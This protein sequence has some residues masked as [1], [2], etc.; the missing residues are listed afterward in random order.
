MKLFNQIKATS[1]ARKFVMG[2]SRKLKVALAEGELRAALDEHAIVAFTDP[3]GKITSVNDKFCTISKYSREELIGQDHRIINS[4]FHSKEF[5]RDLWTTI[6][7]GKVWHGEIKNRAKDGSFYWVDTTIVPFL[8][9]VG[10]PRQYVAIRADITERKR[11]EESRVWLAAIVNSSDDAIIA[12]TLEGII[13]SW[14]SG[15]AKIFGYSAA[16]AIG[17]PM[18]M[19]FPPDRVNEESEIL[20]RI[21]RGESVKHYETIRVRKGGQQVDVSVTIS[22]VTDGNGKIIGA[23]KIARDITERKQMEMAMRDSKTRL[24]STLAAGSIGTWSWDIVNDRLTADEF[25]ARMFSVAPDAA[26]DG[27]PAESYLRAVIE[28]DQTSVADALARAIQS[29]GNYDIEYRVRQ[30]NGELRWVQARGR[31]DGNAAGKAINFHGAVIDITDRKRTEGRFRRLVESNAQGVIFWNRKGEITGANDAFLRVVGYSRDD[32][33]A[34]R[35][36]WSAMTPPEYAEL[37]RIA[38]EELAAKGICNPFEKE[39]IRKD[40]S[41]VP[42]LIGAAIFDDSPD[43]GVCF[44]LDIG[45]RKQTEQALRESEA[46]FR[47]LNELAEATRTLTD[48]SQ[49]M[50]VTARILGKHLRASRCAYAD[51]EQDGERFTI[52]H[53]YTDGCLSTVGSYQLSLFGARALKTL[54]HGQTLIIRSVDGEL[55]PDNGADMFN[56]IGI[57]A[58]IVCP[59]VKNASLRAMM[60]VHQTTPRDWKPSEIAIVQEVVERCWATIE[61]RNA[62]EKIYH[63]NTEL[64]QRV[65]A[66]TAELKLANEELESFSYS[67]SHDLRGPLR[68]MGTYANI[69]G[70]NFGEQMPPEAHAA[71]GRIKGNTKRMGQLID[72]L[73]DF[74]NLSRQSLAK[75]IVDPAAIARDVVEE[76]RSEMAGR[77]VEIEIPELPA[78]QADKMLLHQVYTNLLSNAVKYSR[79]QDPAVIK[80][81]CRTEEGENVYFVQDNGAGFDMEYSAKL[82]HVFQRLHSVEEFDGTGVG[83]AIV[84]RIITR[85]RGRIWAEGKVDQGATFY[86]TLG[87]TH[88]V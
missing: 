15:A 34:G 49:I 7:G 85:H 35:V 57:K 13:T 12:K 26:A 59:L 78:C 37:D 50:T 76:L 43:E 39:Y 61:R 70:K 74:A 9:E 2:K 32:L 30:K 38:L 79:G 45:E 24:K 82:F 11:A 63:L 83:L 25:T 54:R 75:T 81:G 69:L 41:R 72:G 6:A 16:E 19:L 77:R 51:V 80:V 1:P 84:H 3:Q 5:I 73:L 53:D 67:I 55:L 22:P 62:E 28:E 87:E 17:K 29:C 47:F 46:H 21:G 52:L 4:G 36:C 42:I 8:D 44:L 71:L 86:F 60:A 31:V 68:A 10:K 65:T 33:A 14:N 23:S 58:I 18:V 48:A 27:L 64:E 56:A 20:A 66:R 88:H 40:G